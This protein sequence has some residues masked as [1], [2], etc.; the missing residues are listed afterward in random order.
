MELDLL[1]KEARIYDGSGNSWFRADIGISQGKIAAIGKL[2]LKA[3]RTINAT[4]LS[5]C[6]GFVDLHN[7]NDLVALA[8]PNL[9]SHLMQGITTS[10]TG[11]CGLTMA[12]VHKNNLDLLKN[13]LSPFLKPDFDYGWDWTT[14]LQYF[15]KVEQQG[16]SSNLAPLIGQGTIRIAVKGFDSTEAS[17]GEMSEM[18]KLLKQSLEDGILG[19]SSG[20]FYPPG[21]YSSTEELV[22]LASVLTDYNA[23]FSI[24]LRN[25]SDK[26]IESVDEAITVAERN[27]IPLQISH[28]KAAGRANWG[29]IR[30]SLKIIEQARKRGVEVNC[31][32]YPYIAGSTMISSLLPTWVLE[33]GIAN[34]L[35]RLNDR[36][37]RNR[38]EKEISEGTMEGEN[39]IKSIGWNNIVIGGCPSAKQYEGKSLEEIIGGKESNLSSY[40]TFFDWLLEISGDA[41][42]LLFGMDEDDVRT[43]I[44]HPVSTIITDAWATTP[45]GGGKPHPRA[46][47]TFPRVFKKYVREEKILTIEEA[48]RKMTSLPASKIGL[49]N[50]GLIRENCWADLLLF[51]ADTIADKATFSDPHQYPEGIKAIIVNGQIVVEDGKLTENKPGRVLLRE[52][53]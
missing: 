35:R 13:Y 27:G 32:V 3:D 37:S 12:P 45:D 30:G 23:L 43:V 14:N 15:R 22:D 11:N 18:K 28:H 24:H 8:Y 50:R 20:L 36:E 31:D 40:Q 49:R 48:I 44:T 19:M 7:H 21:S 26:L 10:V 1:I 9:E 5:L 52:N 46:Y 2:A 41:I 39:W 6:P 33:G 53:N 47:G 51:N 38:I 42:M 34:M 25:E 4:G 16:I 17:P 29:K